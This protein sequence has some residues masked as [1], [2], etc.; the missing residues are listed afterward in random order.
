MGILASSDRYIQ[1]TVEVV[2]NFIHSRIS[3]RLNPGFIK[4]AQ[5]IIKLTKLKKEVNVKINA[6]AICLK[7]NYRIT[8]AATLAMGILSLTS[9]YLTFRVS[10][11][12]IRKLRQPDLPNS[13]TNS[14]SL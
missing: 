6:T 2:V 14:Q 11:W 9:L 13:D 5:L 4:K 10:N 1:Q 7:T 12:V 3:K 8:A